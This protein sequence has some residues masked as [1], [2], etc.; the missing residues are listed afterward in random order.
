MSHPAHNNA[1]P[2]TAILLVSHSSVGDSLLKTAERLLAVLPSSRIESY[3]VP[4]RCTPE[5]EV[6]KLKQCCRRLDQ[7]GGVL[8]LTD[9]YGATPANVAM[10]LNGAAQC[11]LV[12]GLNLGMLL[13]V[14]NYSHLEGPALA[15]KAYEGGRDSVLK[16][17]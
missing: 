16:L 9:L 10:Q 4:Y 17:W 8:L 6:A 14:L 11:W 1:L 3:T 12:S 2:A 7:G 15:Q 13:K 5:D